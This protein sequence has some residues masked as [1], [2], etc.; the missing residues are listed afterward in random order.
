M[1]NKQ[2]SQNTK[3]TEK[4][5][6]NAPER[7]SQNYWAHIIFFCFVI[8]LIIVSGFIGIFLQIK[9]PNFAFLTIII[10]PILAYLFART[11]HKKAMALNDD[12]YEKTFNM[13]FFHDEIYPISNLHEESFNPLK[14]NNQFDPASPLYNIIGP[15][16]PHNRDH[17]H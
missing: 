15:G 4:Q 17:D 8:P 3:E 5:K 1:E 14:N 12:E 7:N 11:M 6:L 2:E 13:M 9:A 16:A 10:S